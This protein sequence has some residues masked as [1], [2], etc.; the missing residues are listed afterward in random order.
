MQLPSFKKRPP[1]TLLYI[2]EAK[3]FR[4]DTDRKGVIISDVETIE[5]RCESARTLPSCINTI[6]S[7]SSIL[8]KTVWILYSR[9]NTYHIV[10]PAV[11]VAGVDDEILQQ[12][13]QF[14][15]EALTGNSLSNS[16]LAYQFLGTADEMSSYWMNTIAKETFIDIV[17]KLKKP[18]CRLGGLTHPGGFPGLLSGTEDVISWLRIECWSN[19]VFAL[20][21]S[22]EQGF[23]LQ[24]FPIDSD[25]DWHEQIDN[26]ILET[27][28]VDKSEAIMNNQ[29]EYLPSTDENY[30]LTLD[31]ALI[32]WMGQWAQH[33]TAN[34]AADIP[35]INTKTKINMELVYMI[36]GGVAAL[37]L[38]GTHALWMLYQTN[39]YTY[40]LEQLAKTEK[41]LS[42]YSKGL[43]TN[44]EKLTILQQQVATIGGNIKVIPAALKGLQLRPAEL[45]KNLAQASP[46]DLVIEKIKMDEDRIIISGVTLEA[47][48]SNNL[49]GSIEEPLAKVG[50]KVHP[51][52][53]TEMSI[54][55]NG[56]PWSFDMVIEDLG[57]KGFV[58]E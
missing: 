21:K 12:A 47:S 44:K 7:E 52:T 55:D 26:W 41:D 10:L 56:G 35:L 31:G 24:I 45:L 39:E 58:V 5:V 30:H 18:S 22:P 33:F 19:T 42:S 46:E 34:E 40:Q 29:L 57:L 28:S 14:E 23:S 48:L 43:A 37:I 11:Q 4:I 1:H 6:I 25:S 53:K 27:G 32:F 54:F 51:P 36:G 50:W 17:E 9:L 16:S 3:T 20:A 2:T 49:A 13:L 15:Y 38:C 8:G